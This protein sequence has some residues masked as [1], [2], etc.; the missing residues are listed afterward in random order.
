M[1]KY[2]LESDWPGAAV[3]PGNSRHL[4]YGPFI[5]AHKLPATDLRRSDLMTGAQKSGQKRVLVRCEKHRTPRR[6][7]LH[8]REQRPGIINRTENVRGSTSDIIRVINAM[9]DEGALS[10]LG[11]AAENWR[12]IFCGAVSDN[13][14]VTIKTHTR[15]RKWEFSS[16]LLQDLRVRF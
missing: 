15:Y 9:S 6:A 4:L 13:Y 3:Q 11:A 7:G 14:G 5:Q 10:S 8:K 12:I 2:S 1:T 16:A